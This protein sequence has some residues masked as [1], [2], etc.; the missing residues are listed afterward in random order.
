MDVPLEYEVEP[1]FGD[2]LDDQKVIPLTSDFQDLSNVYIN[3]EVW[4]GEIFGSECHKL[5]F[6]GEK[7]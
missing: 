1:V 5:Q 2:V 7:I 6:C 4:C 3:I